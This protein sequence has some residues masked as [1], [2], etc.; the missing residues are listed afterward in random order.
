MRVDINDSSS[1]VIV[2]KQVIINLMN[3]LGFLDIH[4]KE[5]VDD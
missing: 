4:V 5:V 1:E 3:P 2:Y